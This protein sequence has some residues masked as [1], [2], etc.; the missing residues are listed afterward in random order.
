MP[1]NILKSA[2]I[3][4]TTFRDPFRD[5]RTGD[6]S[7]ATLAAAPVT[8]IP[9]KKMQMNEKSP[10]VSHDGSGGLNN[11]NKNF[12]IPRGTKLQDLGTIPVNGL[13]IREHENST[14]NLT[15]KRKFDVKPA[16]EVSCE[17]NDH[18]KASKSPKFS[19]TPLVNNTDVLNSISEVPHD[20]E[21]SKQ[22]GYIPASTNPVD[23][24]SLST[25]HDIPPSVETNP[26]KGK[27][28]IRKWYRMTRRAL[29]RKQVLEILVGRDLAG[30][31]KES[32]KKSSKNS[33]VDRKALD[34]MKF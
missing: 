10:H 29:M 22:A 11:G 21:P 9:R 14:K 4:Q 28:S 15:K 12:T 23:V 6:Q 19:T 31:A 16:Q 3:N 25:E 18:K 5:N 30:P 7:P 24:K 26:G 32:I 13:S 33:K 1:R 17:S 2:S 34:E 27:K 20:L 8:A